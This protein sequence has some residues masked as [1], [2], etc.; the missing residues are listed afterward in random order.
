MT[1]ITYEQTFSLLATRPI[2]SHGHLP[3]YYW[4]G[5]ALVEPMALAL[6]SSLIFKIPISP[7]VK[8]IA[9]QAQRQ[10]ILN[11][12]IENQNVYDIGSFYTEQNPDHD[13][14]YAYSSELNRLLPDR[15]IFDQYPIDQILDWFYDKD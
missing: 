15:T 14:F 4:C 11:G 13:C 10:A 7:E 6:A 3:I 9:G 2:R 8:D 5:L 1:M 12:T